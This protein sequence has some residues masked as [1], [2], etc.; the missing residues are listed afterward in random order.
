MAA[1]AGPIAKPKTPI[2]AR[3]GLTPQAKLSVGAVNDH[4][5]READRIADRVVQGVPLP[6]SSP[7]P[8]ISGLSAQRAT[9]PV[10]PGPEQTEEK[11]APPEKRA[12]RAP[13]ENAP[14]SIPGEKGGAAPRSVESA[15]QRMKAS[16][17]P[18]LDP[19]TRAE[20]EPH[21]GADLSRVRIHTGSAAETA[22]AAL[23]ARAFTVGQD[24][25]FGRNQYDTASGE[26]RR[27][28]AHELVHTVQQT[29]G[30]VRAQRLP[31][32]NSSAPMTRL[33]QPGVNGWVVDLA[34]A[35]ATRPEM[36]L[37][38]LELPMVASALKGTAGGE[39][40]PVA[41]ANRSLPVD[42]AEF[43]L[44]PVGERPEGRA[45]ET[46]LTHL[47]E[48]SASNVETALTAQINAQGTAASVTRGG[49]AVYVLRRVAAA[50]TTSSNFLVGTVPELARSDGILRPM[51]GPQ[52]GDSQLD[53]DHVLELQL[54]GKDAADNMW[55]LAS[56]FNRSV[57]SA[58]NNRINNS[59]RET[60]QNARTAATS[61]QQTDFENQLAAVANPKAVRR[62]WTLRFR[63][64]HVGNFSTTTTFWTQSQIA[65]GAHL[66]FFT[67]L[68]ESELVERGFRFQA[69]VTPT[70]INVFPQPQGGRVIRFAV[71]S[72]GSLERP[73][74]F[75]TGIEI[76]SIE[77]FSPPTNEG[78]GGII[79]RLM[80][81]QTR[82][83]RGSRRT[84]NLFERSEEA[85]PVM[86]QHD[87]RL[88]FGGYVTRE[89][90]ANAFRDIDF[91]PCSPVTFRDVGITSNGELSAIG[92]IL[93][94]K[95]LLPQL[96][97][98]ILLQ[99][100][101][102]VIQ[103]PIPTDR[104]NFGL[105]SVTEAALEMGVGEAGFFIEGNAAIVVDQIGHGSLSARA[106]DGDVI[107]AGTFN[108]DLDFLDPAQIAVSYSLRD[109]ALTA[110]ATLG[111][112]A[113]RLP[114]VESGQ[115][116]VTMSREGVDVNGSL[117]LGGVLT[118]GTITV[119]Y[120]PEAGLMLAGED[121]PLPVSRLPGV[122][123]ATVTVRAVRN[124][125]DG[126]W[127]VSGGGTA[128][129][130]APGTPGT[131]DII[132]E[133]GAII[134]SGRAEVARGPASGWL[135]V[136][137][138]NR[139]IDDKGDPVEGGAVG[140]MAIFGR[141]EATIAFGDFLTGTAGLEYTSDGSIIITGQIAVQPRD[142]FDQRRYDQTLLELES[143]E[144]PIWG[145]SVAGVGVGIFAFANAIV[146]FEASVGPG[147]LRETRVDATIDLDHP[148]LATIEGNAQLFV[149]AYAGL[150]L[151][152]GGGLRAR[153]AVA[154]VQGRVGLEGT[155]GIEA[156]ASA[157][158]NVRWNPADG[159]AVETRLEANA[160]PKF[161]IGVNASVTAGV[162]L[163]VEQIEHTWGPWQRALG[164]FGPEMELGVIFPVRWSERSGLDLSLENLEV[165]RPQLDAAALMSSAFD[166][167]VE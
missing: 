43:R 110:Q 101:E 73:A 114:G 133:G 118:G 39:A 131:L 100:D 129:L 150:T 160:R 51:L 6:A 74:F 97:I 37:P 109:D 135:Q 84:D 99:G 69:G 47:R 165:R 122:T 8:V 83:Q 71:D 115:V 95:A 25:F 92:S 166:T 55:M 62:A 44:D 147:Q 4:Y 151:D 23:G 5:E 63:T 146:R 86:V 21:I 14:A 104:L 113:G 85:Q 153:A 112:G 53:I 91:V 1:S 157:N 130:A 38:A 106:Q 58:I 76:I 142:L 35:G 12:Q 90:I 59:I 13:A 128:T 15:V 144:F 117:A 140:D 164:E 93:S 70:H 18:S 22:A 102:V 45:Y 72:N 88:G 50:A 54:G 116:T 159:F 148:E 138:T 137:A 98:P 82:R 30:T 31:D 105:V 120:T 132:Y 139:E 68:T 56:S 80:V 27:L 103:F 36:T 40:I 127:S 19:G 145:V 124:P 107:I 163:L 81:S 119:G 156:D 67:A 60:L 121:I 149:P 65:A 10:P 64:V 17:A 152:L 154:Y 16:T 46:W 87:A 20:I 134:L 32:G 33:E 161:E 3:G 79:A 77:E 89:S 9:I 123:N 57:G 29:G 158:V 28:V 96:Q 52:G 26:G 141:G 143:P 48:T 167:L 49:D 78:Q 111:V 61:Q 125:D 136:T 34:P 162:D 75:Y 155:L 94:S 24:I 11:V 126:T 41:D 66:H 108:L 7:P 2:L 42:G